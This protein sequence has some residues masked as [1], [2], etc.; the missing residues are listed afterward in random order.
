MLKQPVK[1]SIKVDA[2]LTAAMQSMK[3]ASQDHWPA[4]TATGMMAALF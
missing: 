4:P 3:R 2:V 1:T